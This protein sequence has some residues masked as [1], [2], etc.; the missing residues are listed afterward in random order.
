MRRGICKDN[1]LA[2][3][4]IIYSVARSIRC[5]NECTLAPL[6][7][8]VLLPYEPCI[9]L[10]SG[11]TSLCNAAEYGHLDVVEYLVSKGADEKTANEARTLWA[12]FCT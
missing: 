11:A 6:S 7:P 3:V 4:A 9:L 12:S 10:Q 8:P 2:S 5:S 1:S